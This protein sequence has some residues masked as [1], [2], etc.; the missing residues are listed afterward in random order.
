MYT[1]ARDARCL[2][3]YYH[4]CSQDIFTKAAEMPRGVARAMRIDATAFENEANGFACRCGQNV[5]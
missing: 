2:R 3:C 5:A 4:L 1:H